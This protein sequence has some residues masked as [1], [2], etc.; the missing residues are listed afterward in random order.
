MEKY[1]QTNEDKVYT[2]LL[3]DTSS[4]LKETLAN[5]KVIEK[6][7]RVELERPME[8]EDVNYLIDIMERDWFK[9]VKQLIIN[10]MNLSTEAWEELTYYARSYP[11]Y[12]PELSYIDNNWKELT[13]VEIDLLKGAA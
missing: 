2:Y 5:L 4:A 10:P 13:K 8:D 9:N 1:Q 6:N 7:G 3:I 11:E 12:F